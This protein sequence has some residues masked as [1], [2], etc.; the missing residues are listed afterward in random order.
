MRTTRFFLYAF[1]VS[2]AFLVQPNVSWAEDGVLPLLSGQPAP[3]QGYFV[4]E[5]HMKEGLKQTAFLRTLLETHQL[6]VQSMRAQMKLAVETEQERGKNLLENEREMGRI[7]LDAVRARNGA[8]EKENYELKN[9]P[10]YKQILNSPITGIVLG[11]AIRF[12]L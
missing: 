11:I 7:E 6:E 8:L 3:R 12:A 9:P 4:D 2:L 5:E 1:L 10:W